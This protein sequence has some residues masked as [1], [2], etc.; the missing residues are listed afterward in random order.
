[1]DTQEDRSGRNTIWAPPDLWAV[2]DNKVRE[3]GSSNPLPLVPP[4]PLQHLTIYTYFKKGCFS[5]ACFMD[6]SA[7]CMLNLW[8][9]F[10]SYYSTC[11]PKT[12][13]NVYFS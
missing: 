1:M 3:V 10:S 6:R 11:C 7:S 12:R 9:P 2:R 8:L 4:S 5:D 13:A